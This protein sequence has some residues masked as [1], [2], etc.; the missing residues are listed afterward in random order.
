MVHAFMTDQP[1]KIKSVLLKNPESEL[2]RL[3]ARGHLLIPRNT[4]FA[5]YKSAIEFDLILMFYR[6]QKISTVA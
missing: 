4:I 2:D 5:A 3:N 6:N 1:Y